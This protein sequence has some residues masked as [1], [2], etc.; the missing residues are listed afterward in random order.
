MIDIYTGPACLTCGCEEGVHHHYRPGLDCG[1]CGYNRCSIYK[2]RTTV[3]KRIAFEVVSYIIALA[4]LAGVILY[5]K[6]IF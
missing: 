1:R 4:I 2:T 5:V 3:A 6:W